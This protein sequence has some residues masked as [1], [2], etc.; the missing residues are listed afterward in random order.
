MNRIAETLRRGMSRTLAVL[1][2]VVVLPGILRAS[3][4]AAQFVPAATELP[5]PDAPSVSM[6]DSS[7][8]ELRGGVELAR[9]GV[10]LLRL[11]L[12]SA[13]D[14]GWGTQTLVDL[15]TRVAQDLQ[16]L[17]DHHDVPLRV[18]N[19]SLRHGGEMRWSHSHHSGRDVDVLL[20]LMDAGGK[21]VAPD[22]FVHLDNDGRG[23]WKH[24]PVQFDAPRMWH[25]VRALL[26]DG[27]V[28]VQHLYLAEPL[29]QLV[30]RHARAQGEPEWLLQRAL[31]VISEPGHSGKHDD[32]MHVRLYC[33]RDDRLAGCSDDEPRWPWVQGYD[34][35]VRAQVG[36]IIAELG[37][38]DP[39]RRAEALGR[40]LWFQHQD[41]RAIEALIHAAST[42]GPLNRSLA[43]EAMEKL[44]EPVAF[45]LLMRAALSAPLP[46]RAFELLESAVR[47]A[48][49]QHAPDLLGMLGP[50]CGTVGEYLD[51][52][53]CSGLRR[54][55]AQAVRPWLMEQSA[56]PL[57]DVLADPDPGTRRA[58]LRTL[59]HLANRR[60][61]AP[62]QA[63][64]WYERAGQ[65][66]RLQWMYEGFALRGVAVY[67][68]PHIL[69]PA[70]IELLGNRDSSL[71]ANAEAL[72][73][74]VVDGGPGELQV[75]ATR[76]QRA[77]SRWWDVNHLR[78]DWSDAAA[79]KAPVF[80]ASG[81]T[82]RT[83]AVSEE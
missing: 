16:D 72:L 41:V 54:E 3:V 83:P 5:V 11:S 21:P 78:Y 38:P 66:G 45:A 56:A 76:R 53:R 80:D 9:R 31:L 71:A 69:A 13:R 77:W 28:Q 33:S 57:L 59:E 65:L 51:I 67:A 24:Q 23:R 70:L 7:R 32:H 48:G 1:L 10:G 14:S 26:Q 36:R 73:A 25:A 52:T 74:R 8:G 79:A 49:P 46:E 61:A 42:E 50:D 35:E 29:R 19:L 40:L 47:V 60:F 39:S 30:L 44:R 62:S 34:H 58:A 68:P 4:A 64:A 12:V 2:L 43:L 82:P 15:V 55:V 75:T 22:E 27:H 17:P 37:E 81:A 20:Y 18:G 63:I 6:G